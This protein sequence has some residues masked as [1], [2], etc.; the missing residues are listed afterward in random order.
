MNEHPPAPAGAYPPHRRAGTP[1]V[2]SGVVVLIVVASITACSADGNPEESAS[3][4]TAATTTA[5]RLQTPECHPSYDPC[6][7][8]A[9]DIDCVGGSGN[10]PEYVGTVSVIGVDEYDLD[11]DADGVGCE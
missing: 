9:S 4:G 3:D 10:G 8:M 7:P 2:I 6:V 1:G 11:R 5:P